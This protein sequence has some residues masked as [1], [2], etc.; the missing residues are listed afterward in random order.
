MKE[1]G[2]TMFVQGWDSKSLRMGT[3]TLE[4]SYTVKHMETAS[5]SGLMEKCLKGNG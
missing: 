3:L 2:R 5:T 4:S 1:T